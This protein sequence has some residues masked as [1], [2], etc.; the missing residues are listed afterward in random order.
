MESRAEG[1]CPTRAKYERGLNSTYPLPISVDLVIRLHCD[2]TA[3]KC[4]GRNNCKC[5]IGNM[6]RMR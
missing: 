5:S 6:W 3:S 4:K 2:L 1:R